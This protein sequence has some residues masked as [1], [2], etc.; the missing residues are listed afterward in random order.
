MQ[1]PVAS[2]CM[3]D[4]DKAQAPER[5]VPRTRLAGR[6]PAD[7]APSR[8]VR[9]GSLTPLSA[10]GSSLSSH[11]ISCPTHQTGWTSRPETGPW[12][13]PEAWRQRPLPCEGR[14]PSLRHLSLALFNLTPTPLPQSSSCHPLARSPPGWAHIW[15]LVKPLGGLSDCWWKLTT[16]GD[17]SS[18]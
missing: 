15:R 2:L 3:G 6:V 11:G 1:P 13:Q 14:G 17:S 7:R 5:W 10:Q 8:G 9:P 18:S 12:A 4:Q 16:S